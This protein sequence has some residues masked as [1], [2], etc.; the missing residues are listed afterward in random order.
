MYSW[1]IDT[2]TIAICLAVHV[3]AM[4]KVPFVPTEEK[5]C[6]SSSFPSRRVVLW[7]KCRPSYSAKLYLFYC[8]LIF[9]MPRMSL[10]CHLLYLIQH[11]I[12]KT[13]EEG[14]KQFSCYCSVQYKDKVILGIDR[15]EAIVWYQLLYSSS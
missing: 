11:I 13:L 1:K 8:Y 4:F 10:F 9:P 7:R 2:V 14:W 5:V 3:P 15:N 6:V 12:Y